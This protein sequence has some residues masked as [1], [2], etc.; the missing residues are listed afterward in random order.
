MI[1]RTHQGDSLDSLC[2]RHLGTSD[3]IE[4]T[5]LL[6]PGLAAAGAILPPGTPVTLP[7]AVASTPR[8]ELI[9]LWD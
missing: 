1:V 8:T 6:N 3:A 7:D 2:W 4:Q 5:L 9:N